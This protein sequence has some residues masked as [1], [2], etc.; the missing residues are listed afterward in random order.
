MSVQF[1]Q[2]NFDGK[3][4][5]PHDLEAARPILAPYGPDGEGLCCQDNFGVLYRAFHTTRES[6]A[7]TQ[8][9]ISKS[10]AVIT[11]DGRLDNRK[12]LIER[13]AD[14]LSTESTDVDIVATGYDCLG[15]DTLRELIGDWALSIW[16]P[17]DQSLLLAKD[18]VGTRHIFYAIEGN[19]VTWCTILDPLVLLSRH[20]LKL[21]EEFVAGWLSFFSTAHVTPYIGI[22]AVCP[23]SFIRFTQKTKQVIRYWDFDPAKRIRYRSDD[24]YEEHFRAVFSQSVD[25]RLRSD[26]PILAELSGGMDSSSVVCLADQIVLSDQS[27][28]KPVETVSYYD[29]SEPNWDERPFFNIVETKRGKIGHHIDVG[30]QQLSPL[31]IKERKFYVTPKPIYRSQKASEDFAGCLKECGGRVVLSGIA[32]DEVTGGVPTAN[33]EL[34]D[35]LAKAQLRLLANRLKVWA[36]EKRKPWFHILLE[37]INGF[38]PFSLLAPSAMNRPV[39]WLSNGFS[40]RY[41]R[42]LSGYSSRLKLFG[43]LPSFQENIATLEALRRQLGCDGPNSEPL[44]E[45][46]YPYLDR[47]LLEFLFAIP[48]EQLVRPGQRRSLMRRALVGIVPDEILNRKRKAYVSRTP[49]RA[50]SSQAAGIAATVRQ[51]TLTTLGITD[52]SAFGETLKRVRIGQEDRIVQ[53][54]RTLELE[55]WLQQIAAH[56][57]VRLERP[58]QDHISEFV[59]LAHRD[60]AQPGRM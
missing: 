31:Q 24:Q 50:L 38:L 47:D 34:Q 30:K 13:F 1:G 23:S 15:V 41:R 60:S 10:G 46:R 53:L 26:S 33:P 11:W 45:V 28:R 21:E 39:P 55:I 32:G 35:L 37:A 42:A 22:Q 9:Y 3:S 14:R 8:P 49:I 40:N 4:V 56:G 20:P 54:L 25:R 12:N 57:I 58:E 36:L 5:N 48:R 52:S 27:H 6:R 18:F 2:F 16:S 43:P 7:E 17:K 44:Y 59:R 29:D 51:M 19:Q